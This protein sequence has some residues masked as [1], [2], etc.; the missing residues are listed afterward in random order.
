[1]DEFQDDTETLRVHFDVDTTQYRR[2]LSEAQLLGR[3]F[4]GSL[5]RAFDGL[6][7][8]GKSFGDVLKS[9]ALD[10]SRLVLKSALKPLEQG[11]GNLFSGL[12]SGGAGFANGGVLQSGTPT[13]FAKGGVIASPVMFP[14]GQGGLGL[15]GEAGPE[16]ILPLR[17]GADGRLGVASTNSGASSVTVTMNISTP[18]AMSFQRSQTQIAARLARAVAVGQRN[19]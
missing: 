7:L 4:A 10:L 13:P 9:L 19:F 1:M 18:D 17:R 11:L 2:G 14:M 5:S 3:Q 16:A 6:A 15:A 12:F 8:R